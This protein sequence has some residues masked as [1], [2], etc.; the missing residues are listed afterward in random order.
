MALTMQSKL[1]RTG[2]RNKEKITRRDRFFDE[3]NNVTPWAALVAQIEPF[4][5]K[6]QA[7][8]R[9]LAWRECCACTSPNN[10]LASS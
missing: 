10:A 7:A 2:I 1:P 9:R 4:G 3:I 5:K 8:D 6:E